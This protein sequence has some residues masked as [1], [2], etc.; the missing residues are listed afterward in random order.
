MKL[1]VLRNGTNI[2][3]FN[4][5]RP[6]D[7][8]CRA[9]FS[10]FSGFSYLRES[11]AMTPVWDG[12]ESLS[13]ALGSSG[14]TKRLVCASAGSGAPAGSGVEVLPVFGAPVGTEGPAQSRSFC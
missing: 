3:S 9:R 11:S 10:R 14:P 13:S 7:A 6:S 1:N 4:S 8:G 5:L 2:I 12:R